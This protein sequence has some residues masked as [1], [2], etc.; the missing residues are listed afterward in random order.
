MEKDIKDMLEWLE[1]KNGDGSTLWG[2]NDLLTEPNTKKNDYN[3]FSDAETLHKIFTEE[4]LEFVRIIVNNVVKAL[5]FHRDE[6][7]GVHPFLKDKLD[8]TD[9]KLRNHRHNLDQTYSAKAEF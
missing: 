7:D 5:A 1:D 6:D 2:M 4:Q 9:A 8:N 3:G